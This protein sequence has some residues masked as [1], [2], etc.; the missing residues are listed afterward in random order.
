MSRLSIVPTSKTKA[1][2]RKIYGR[3]QRGDIAKA[4]RNQNYT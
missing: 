4:D 2:R 1:S 3:V